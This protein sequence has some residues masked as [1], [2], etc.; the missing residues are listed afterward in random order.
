MKKL[1]S[2]LIVAFLLTQSSSPAFGVQDGSDAT[3]NSFVV[4]VYAKTS[5]TNHWVCSGALLAPAIVA[6]AGH[7]VL[8]SNGLISTDIRVGNA[9]S[10]NY[11]SKNL[12]DTWTKATSVQ[13]TPTFRGGSQI[14]AD[15][16]IFIILSRPLPMPVKVRLASESEV[17]SLKN[18]G[19]ELKM[20]GYGFINDE[21]AEKRTPNS[22]SGTYSYETFADANAFA[23]RSSIGN[24][25][26]GDSGGPMIST[27][28]TE[29]IVV[30]IITGGRIGKNCSTKEPGG[31]YVTQGM[32]LSRYSNLAFSAAVTYIS[33][34]ESKLIEVQAK[35]PITITCTKGKLTKKVSGTNPK[36][37]KGY[38][39]TS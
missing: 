10:E 34:L 39:K 6:T 27:T 11:N 14:S 23:T 18:S 9:G 1:I 4:P 30:G 37:P 32:L 5:E 16:V 26:R 15:D 3:N 38:T 20:L 24:P 22:Y 13:I 8:D 35:L 19:A 33:G 29:I 17:I 21:G 7:C 12:F 31:Y 28:A 36:C 2:I 25:C